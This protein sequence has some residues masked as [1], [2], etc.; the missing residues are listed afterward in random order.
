M[1]TLGSVGAGARKEAMELAAVSSAGRLGAKV[2][3]V[4]L[5]AQ[6]PKRDTASI[7]R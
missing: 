2:Q 7:G 1:V 6:C 4:R 5:E 3:G